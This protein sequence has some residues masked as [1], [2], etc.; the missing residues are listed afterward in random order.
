[1]ETAHGDLEACFSKLP[2]NGQGAGKLVALNAY[3]AN[4]AAIAVLFEA[5]DDALDEY[6][7]IRL[8][9]GTNEELGVRAQHLLMGRVEC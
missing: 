8:V 3:Q 4:Q 5:T 7:R 9:V 2:T 6:S 1:M